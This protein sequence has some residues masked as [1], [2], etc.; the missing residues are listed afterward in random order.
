MTKKLGSSRGFSLVEMMIAMVILS[1]S[2][3]AMSSATLIAMKTNMKNEVRNTAS[4]VAKETVN[5]LFAKPFSSLNDGT[6]TRTVQVRGVDKT[7][8]T[9][10]DVTEVSG[11]LQ[12]ELNVQYKIGTAEFVNRRVVY[13]SNS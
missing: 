5:D 2:I 8:T 9:S 7:F 1:V 13:R 6:A 4:R 12:V 10:W 3:L 11:V